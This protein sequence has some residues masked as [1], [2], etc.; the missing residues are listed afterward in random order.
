MDEGI[1]VREAADL[2]GVPY[3]KLQRQLRR[4]RVNGYKIGWCWFIPRTEVNRLKA[5]GM[6][7]W[8][9]EKSQQRPEHI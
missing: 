2:I 8:T 7:T 4:G 3:L 1:P 9:K 5:E 6:R